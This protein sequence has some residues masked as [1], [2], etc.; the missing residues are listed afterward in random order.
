VKH[1]VVACCWLPST[2]PG[3]TMEAALEAFRSWLSSQRRATRDYQIGEASAHDLVDTHICIYINQCQASV[4]SGALQ[5]VRM[6]E[7]GLLQCGG[8]ELAFGVARVVQRATARPWRCYLA[9]S[10]LQAP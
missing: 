1:S 10:T 3:K 6:G 9:L 5:A 4:N 7:I 8:R 2:T